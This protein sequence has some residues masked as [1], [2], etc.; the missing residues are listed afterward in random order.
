[1]TKSTRRG[2][3]LVEL[4]VVIAIIATL[5]GLLLPAVQSA[6]EAGR[7][8]TCMNNLKQLG[9][10][11]LSYE[12]E[13][14]VLP[15]WRNPHPNSEVASS[16]QLG[17]VSWPILL[18]PGLERRD[19]YKMWEQG[20][21]RATGA[22]LPAGTIAPF[23]PV[24]SCPSSLFDSSLPNLAY[25]A[26][27][28]VGVAGRMQHKY[29]SVFLD[30]VG[31]SKMSGGYDLARSNLD[32]ISGGDGTSMTL[33]YS[34]K[35]GVQE[36]DGQSYINP[37]QPLLGPETFRGFYDMAPQAANVRY[38]FEPYY[39]A[40]N[41]AIDSQW[42]YPIPGFGALQSVPSTAASMIMPTD[43]VINS[44][45]KSLNGGYG[46][47]S[48]EHTGGVLVVFCDGHTRFISD[49][50]DWKV[51]CQLLTPNS[52]G[53]P[54]PTAMGVVCPGYNAVPISESNY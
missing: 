38:S 30:T 13:R 45:T 29:D 31:S 9:L 26:N 51:Y 36:I 14:Q 3:T 21:D 6:R 23:L 17:C 12:S 11:T 50:L 42:V 10:A 16:Q 2:F 20:T 35:S 37:R 39:P 15:G 32:F 52:T 19:V 4:L 25:A 18:L 5:I 47:P 48:S 54:A 28:G 34:E 24:F 46:R 7:R 27:M 8:S 33:M 44:R 22:M 49:A 43:S 1:M 53:A 41:P 40:R